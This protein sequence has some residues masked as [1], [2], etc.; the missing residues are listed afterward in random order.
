VVL[1]AVAFG[2]RLN[3]RASLALLLIL[4]G[5]GISQ[6]RLRLWPAPRLRG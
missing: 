6:G 5:I 2:E 1:G 3:G 4:L